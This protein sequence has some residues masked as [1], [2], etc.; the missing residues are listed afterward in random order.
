MED[1]RDLLR[2]INA[3]KQEE[4]GEQFHPYTEKQWSYFCNPRHTFHR[5][6]HFEIPKK[7]GGMRSIDAPYSSS[8]MH[9]LRYVAIVLQSIYVPSKH[10]MGFVPGRSIVDNAK[11]HV[12]MNYVFNLDLKD[13]FPSILRTRIMRR[14]KARPFCFKPIVAFNIAGLCTMRVENK[15]EDADKCPYHYVL[16]QGSPAS[17]V[18]TNIMC[19]KLDFLLSALA[20]RFGLRYTRYAD[21]ITFSSL[22]NVYQEGSE[23]RTELARIIADQSFTINEAKTRLNTI[24]FRREVTGLTVSADK[25]NVSRKYI[26]DLRGLLYIWEQYGYTEAQKRLYAHKDYHR[27]IWKGRK[28]SS[29]ACVVAGK[30]A[31]VKMVKGAEDSTYLSLKN[32]YDKLMERCAENQPLHTDLLYRETYSI[33]E[34]EKKKGT[35]IKFEEYRYNYATKHKQAGDVTRIAKF[36]ID[37]E[38]HWVEVKRTVNPLFI[39]SKQLYISYCEHRDGSHGFWLIHEKYI[40]QKFKEYV[41]ID[42][43]NEELDAL[44]DN[45]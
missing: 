1:R 41:N 31:F 5:Y 8:Y 21:D 27:L 35:V 34:F 22:H 9:L 45:G 3:I 33:S 18:L 28:G 39:L 13:F 11:A 43:L 23:F 37:G 16:P 30:I 40:S 42:K 38:E 10:T 14:L 19:E 4:L 29:L 6:R 36:V 24:G 44:L 17:P 26:K 7:S 2:L 12:G 32:R 15:G 20:K 25:V